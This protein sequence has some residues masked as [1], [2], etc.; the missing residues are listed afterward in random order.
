MVYFNVGNAFGGGWAI[1]AV[2]TNNTHYTVKK[3]TQFLDADNYFKDVFMPLLIQRGYAIDLFEIP[4]ENFRRIE[5][6]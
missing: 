4:P 1:K 3:F 2:D 6:L 5:P